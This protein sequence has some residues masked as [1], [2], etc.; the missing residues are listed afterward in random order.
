MKQK[1]FSLIEILI[2]LA[3]IG[4][5]ASI[6][7]IAFGDARVKA[8]DTKRKSDI[9]TIG[10]FLSIS[11]YLPDDGDGVYD[12]AE[13]I[14]GLKTKYP[15]YQNIISRTPRDPKS[16]TD[17]ITHYVYEVSDD[18]K[19][20]TLYTNLENQGEPITLPNLTEPTPGGGQGVLRA[21][22]EGP[23]NTFIY[24]QYTN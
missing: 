7:Y 2:T 16:G 21:S 12:V 19:K 20:C 14:E 9:A 23:N 18:G 13:L 17:T 10:R 4:V 5:I 15:Q 11:C 24:F 22:T 1:G 6:G 8:R 3:I